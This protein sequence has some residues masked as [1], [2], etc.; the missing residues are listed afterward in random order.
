MSV[1][2]AAEEVV[3]NAEATVN[4][5][6]A[7]LGGLVADTA[8]RELP[9][10]GRDW[11]QL[12]TL[13]AG[14]VGGIGLDPG[15]QGGNNSSAARGNGITLSVAGSRPTN[16]VFVVDN[17]IVN[18]FSNGSPGSGLGVNLGVDGIQEFRV[19]TNEYTAQYG[20]TS[21]GVV[22]AAYKS[23]T[24]DIHGS[25][26]GFLRNSALD[27]RN[28]FDYPT[29][30]SFRRGQF[31]GSLSGPIKKDK[32]F[33]FGNYESLREVKGLAQSSLTLSLPARQGI[34]TTGNVTVNPAIK[35]F[36]AMFPLPNGQ[37][38]GDTAKFNFAAP[39]NGIEHYALTKVDQV[40][41]NQ[42][43]LSGSFQFDDT[44]VTTP[45]PYNEK[46]VG[47]P[48]RHY[49]T[50]LNL[51][52]TFSP[53]LLNTARIGVSRTVASDAMDVTAINPVATDASLAFIPGKPVG[54]IA[55][56]GL[57]GTSG[58]MGASG[59]DIFHYNSV[60][61][62]DDASWIKG[63]H[64]WRFGATVDKMQYNQNS[65]SSPLG[66]WD[67]DSVG[68]F[69]Q[70]IASKYTSDVPGT[71]DIRQL[72]SVYVGAYLQDDFAFRQN[73]KFTLGLRYEFLTETTEEHGRVALLP[74]LTSN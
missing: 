12:A 51:Q 16:N 43:M 66:E 10:N 20:R 22:D 48:S 45:D 35:P 19:L 50:V 64:T 73:L 34:L 54:V 69:L 6:D 5:T 41:S 1:G 15:A 27:A 8:I 7:S 13:Q 40:F 70:G 44:V 72:R 61:F 53:T 59:A 49:N 65:V 62:G 71:N 18:D 55:V 57:T 56:A 29:K 23:G 46:N 21:A 37:V 9:L 28:F 32:T 38:T 17:L 42:T 67:F 2:A 24:N 47:S 31:G 3:V 36:L 11:L 63:K 68:Q 60:Q 33:I 14:V 39:L 25:A 26:F 74:S 30:P 52:H 58:G 4:T